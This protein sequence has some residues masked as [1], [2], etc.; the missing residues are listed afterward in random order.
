MEL[1]MLLTPNAEHKKVFPNVPVLGFWNSKSLDEYFSRAA[2]RKLKE[3]GRCEPCGKRACFLYDSIST[4][5]T[6]KTEASQET[7]KIRSGSLTCDSEKVFYLLKCKVYGKSNFVIC[8]TIM[9]VNV[10]LLERVGSQ[11]VPREL[12][13]THCCRNNHS[14]IE[15]WD[16][17]FFLQCKI[18]AQLKEFRVS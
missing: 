16:F 6:F 18:H 15:D 12:F 1:H 13:H 17:L 2:L 10:E 7:F 9:K 4:A 11:K 14:G 3:S 5:A 8:L